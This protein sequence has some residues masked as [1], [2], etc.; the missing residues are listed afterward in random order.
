[1]EIKLNE[2]TES[3]KKLGFI[4]IKVDCNLVGTKQSFIQY[5]VAMVVNIYCHNLKDDLYKYCPPHTYKDTLLFSVLQSQAVK[6]NFRFH[7]VTDEFKM[8]GQSLK[9]FL[10]NEIYSGVYIATSEV[11]CPHKDKEYENNAFV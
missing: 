9:F 11:Y 4:D 5:F 8:N 2:V 7:K 10:L 6:T 3:G 1:M